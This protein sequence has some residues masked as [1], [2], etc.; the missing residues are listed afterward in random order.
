M[1]DW[2]ALVR[3][4]MGSFGLTH[5][6]EEEVVSELACHLEDCYEE[7]RVQGLS[8]SE[9]ADH[10]LERVADWHQLAQQIQRAKHKEEIVNHRTK[11]LWLPG[12]IGM[13]LSAGWM[14]L[15][16]RTLALGQAPWKHAGLP[17]GLY[18]LWLTSLPLFGAMS[19]YSSKRLGGE[20]LSRIAASLFL[21]IVMF[22]FWIAVTI[23]VATMVDRR[24]VQ[25]ANLFLTALN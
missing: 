25:W 5:D 20:R 10:A 11:A 19:A 7:L 13:A 3:K 6:V 18:L 17:L 24:P 15:L 12:L 22:L 8:E 4:H 21:P 16:Q 9:A 2:K 23:H 14:F 1:P